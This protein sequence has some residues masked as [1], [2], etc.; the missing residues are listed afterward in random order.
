MAQR[1]RDESG[2]PQSTRPRDAL[3]RPLPPGSNGVP[4]IPE[5]LELPPIESLAYAQ[6]LLNQGLAFNAHEVLEAAWKR[7]P[8]NERPLWQGLAQLA[9]GITHAQRGN[10]VGAATL[11]RRGSAHLGK[12][13]H[14]APYS[15]DVDGLI[16]WAAA[17]VNDLAARAEISPRRLRPALTKP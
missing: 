16:G 10:P 14:P 1:D 6:G 17:L 13:H 2:R 3:G 7:S 15:V 4:R 11:L 8:D 5:R 12:V 9:V